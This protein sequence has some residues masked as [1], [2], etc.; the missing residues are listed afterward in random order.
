MLLRK[1]KCTSATDSRWE[2][3][4]K[5]CVFTSREVYVKFVS[6]CASLELV[7]FVLLQDALTMVTH[8]SV[9]KFTFLYFSTLFYPSVFNQVSFFLL[10]TPD[11]QD[12]LVPCNFTLLRSFCVSSEPGM[13][14]G[15]WMKGE[16]RLRLRLLQP[17]TK[18]P[19]ARFIV[20]GF[21]VLILFAVN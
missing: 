11:L 5:L 3:F 12:K 7:F 2:T 20:N 10:V 15:G 4:I 6:I 18:P 19:C 13:A 1:V 14:S 8:D 16:W 9:H 17:V 21:Y